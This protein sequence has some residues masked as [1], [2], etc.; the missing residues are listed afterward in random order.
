MLLFLVERVLFRAALVLMGLHMIRAVWLARRGA[1]EPSSAP[2]GDRA[3]W[4]RVT[5]QIPIR[6]EFYV[7]ERAILAAAALDYPHELLEIQVVDDSDDET[8]ILVD[9]VVERLSAEGVLVRACRRKTP[10]GFK[11]GALAEA[12]R[13]ARG[14]FVAIFDADCVPA[15]DFLVRTLPVLLANPKVGLVQA[16]WTFLNRDR[17]LL[18][19]LQA[20]LLDGLML[21]EQAGRSR[22]G[23]S[24]QF[25]GTSGV[26]RRSAIE[27][28]G[29]WRAGALT[30]DLEL[31]FRARLAGVKLVHLPTVE[32]ATELTESMRAYRRQQSRWACGNAQALREIGPSVV[33]SARSLSERIQM[34]AHIGRRLLFVALAILTVTFPL[35]TFEIVRPPWEFGLASD[36]ALVLWTFLTVG[37]YLGT[38]IR[39]GGS[40]I[41]P[42]FLLVPAAIGLNLGLALAQTVG[43]VRGLVPGRRTFEV[44]PKTGGLLGNNTSG[45][46][47]RARFDPLCI[48]ECAIGI[49]YLGFTGYALAMSLFAHAAFMVFVA[50]SYLSVG[51][52]TLLER[53]AHD[54]RAND[55]KPVRPADEATGTTRTRRLEWLVFA[56]LF[57]SAGYFF[58]PGSWNANSRLNVAM[59]M[60]E[61]HT[62][63]IDAYHANTKDKAF[64]E[65]HYYSDKAPGTALVAA[66][67]Y[68][69]LHMVKRIAPGWIGHYSSVRLWLVPHL[70]SGLALALTGLLLVRVARRLGTTP[71]AAAGVALGYGLSTIAFPFGSVLFGHDLAAF[72]C[73]ASFAT[74]VWTGGSPVGRHRI[75]W[76]GFIAGWA[77]ITEYPTAGISAIIAL[78]AARAGR[79][80]FGARGFA[81]F[82]L[83]ALA[84]L[85][86]GAAY[87]MVSFGR[88]FGVGYSHLSD[89]SWAAGMNNTGF[90]GITYPHASRLLFLLFTPHRGLFVYSPFAIIGFLGLASLLLC[91][92]GP[93][94]LAL[95]LSA[96]ATAYLLLFVSSFE[97]WAGGWSFGPRHLITALPFVCLAAWPIL[98]RWPRAALALGLVSTFFAVVG[99]TIGPVPD[100]SIAHPLGPMIT[101]FFQG[102]IL[103]NAGSLLGLRGLSTLLPLLAMWCGAG[104]LLWRWSL[105]PQPPGAVVAHAPGQTRPGE[106]APELTQ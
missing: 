57:L 38:A 20:L 61:H 89:P 51:A 39:L 106:A 49:L 101:R 95:A 18:T 72:L 104:A 77:F 23:L 82:A 103:P 45:P 10:E 2:L 69:I 87:G 86:I 85:A 30:E 75:V 42:V 56:I 73:F 32:V 91:K 22:A 59:A 67:P 27:S 65:G 68:S 96:G 34:L 5:V 81:W 62:T 102:R 17:S 16:R 71:L 66:V 44:T 50:A 100:E 8:V 21:V 48:L 84:P 1:A 37:L 80:R 12:L 54:L 43:I 4:P 88:P 14:E 9:R 60:V 76:A 31:S 41:A 83:G 6:N 3:N 36:A 24:F 15:P 33:V 19:K 79:D 55:T 29:G 40:R 25:N 46:R 94:R 13:T 64:F 53:P 93:W 28:A 7:V 105:T 78:Y 63:A 97:W 99:V 26:W 58:V 47:Y 98:E 52:A 70:V 35:T 74:V 90:F 92:P 11:A